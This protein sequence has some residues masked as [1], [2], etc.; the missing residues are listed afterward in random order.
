LQALVHTAAETTTV[1]NTLSRSAEHRRKIHT[2][3]L[4]LLLLLLLQQVVGGHGSLTE[5]Y[6]QTLLCFH[7]RYW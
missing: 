2:A 3:I 4:Q 6:K 5:I 7:A 1:F